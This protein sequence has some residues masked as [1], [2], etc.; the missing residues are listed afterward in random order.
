MRKRPASQSFQAAAARKDAVPHVFGWMADNEDSA[1]NWHKIPRERTI[2]ESAVQIAPLPPTYLQFL[3]SE[4][5]VAQQQVVDLQQRLESVDAMV[6][7][8]SLERFKD[9]PE[10]MAFYTGLPD[11]K[12]LML[13]YSSDCTSYYSYSGHELVAQ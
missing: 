4:L 7:Q 5:Q 6:K 1:S 13:H 8:F 3:E 10:K 2:R 12:A 9:S 11:C